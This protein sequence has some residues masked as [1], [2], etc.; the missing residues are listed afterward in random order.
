LNLVLKLLSLTLFAAGVGALVM[1]PALFRSGFDNKFSAGLEVL[2]WTLTYCAWFGLFA[3]AQNYLWC[4]ERAGLAGLALFCGLVVNIGLNFWLLPRWGLHGAVWAVAVA[5]CATL[6][7]VY[8][9]C[10]KIGMQFHRGAWFLSFSLVALAG[11]WLVATPVLVLLLLA[12][13]RGE[14]LFDAD[15]KRQM[16]VG[17]QN[18]QR[19][20][21]AR[22]HS[23]NPARAE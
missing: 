9:F 20:A 16:L 19:R 1:A 6:A 7:L 11:G 18:Y 3:V 22:F 5:N 17:W 2:P 21:M 12:S 8:V 23:L 10:A 4:A 14:L 15:E 13:C